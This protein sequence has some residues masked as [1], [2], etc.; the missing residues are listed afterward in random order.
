MKATEFI[1]SYLCKYG[2]M[3]SVFTFA[4]GTNA[5]L[6]DA[7]YRTKCMGLVVMR[8]EQNAAFAA[9]G[10]AR[11][12]EKMGLALTMSGPGA[13]NLV[14]GIANAYF[15][16]AP[17]FYLTGQV[18]SGSYKYDKPVRQ[19]GY[20]ET[21]IVSIVKPITKYAAVA[22]KKQDI[23]IMLR[24]AMSECVSGR[25]G[26]VLADF[27]MDFQKED[28]SEDEL[29][30][31][32][33]EK[34]TDMPKD[35]D[36]HSVISAIQASKRPVIIIG[37]GIRA[38]KTTEQLY[39]FAHNFHIPVVSSLL[40]KDS[41]PNDDPLY[42]GFIGTYGDRYANLTMQNSDLIIALG[43]RLDSRQT[44][45]PATFARAAKK[46]HVEIDKTELNNTVKS[47]ISINC[48]L[49]NFFDAVLRHAK[50]AKE[51]AYDDWMNHIS[52]MKKELKYIIDA[53]VNPKI[54]LAKLSDAFHDDEIFTTDVG[55]NQMWSAQALV[56]RKNQRFLTSGGLG[57]MQFSIPAAIGAYFANPKRT[58]IAIC[59]DG[60]FQMSIPEL[61]TI[62]EYKI[63]LKIVVFNNGVLGLMRVFQQENF[64]GRHPTTEI[65]YS[66]PDIKK[67]AEAYGLAHILIGKNSE[68]EE[69]IAK[70]KKE[71]RPV[72]IE[73]VI[74]K[75]LK[76]YPK[77]RGKSLEDQV[78]TMDREELKK[79]MLVPLLDK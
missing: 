12:S 42:V 71:T 19:L 21:D 6:I 14:T 65:G 53:D 45:S 72:I 69:C 51:G 75:E 70:A 30:I 31:A 25:P 66:C 1:T 32:P 41:F 34:K 3:H 11:A 16:S 22:R 38:S 47:D 10:Y 17:V 24:E 26:S 61:Q 49:K 33:P 29:S 4:G 58:V 78:P 67:L 76:A 79:Y 13:T 57:S 7:I 68:I 9:E 27:P 77:V 52:L 28:I 55:N 63:P 50:P 56:I 2:G 54:F 46:I 48:D 64:E 74:D 37:G 62:M 39:K 60:G 59:G 8:H 36:I 73:V 44:A 40:G 18:V 15:D 43:T 5:F 23:P 20:Q 35:E